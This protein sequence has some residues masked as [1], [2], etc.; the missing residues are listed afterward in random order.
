MW[1]R[2]RVGGRERDRGG[3]EKETG[4]KRERET[5]RGGRERERLKQRKGWE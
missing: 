3:R 2:N 5:D 1:K 4:W